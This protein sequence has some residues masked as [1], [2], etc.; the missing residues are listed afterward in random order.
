MVLVPRGFQSW[1]SFSRFAFAREFL[2][3]GAPRERP[4]LEKGVNLLTGILLKPYDYFLRNIYSPP[5]VAAVTL[6][7]LVAVTMFFYPK[8]FHT[9]AC[10]ILP[11]FKR[12]QAKHLRFT[13]FT[14]SQ[15]LIWGIGIRTLSRLNDSALMRAWVQGRAVAVPLGAERV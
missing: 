14:L 12:L 9:A 5:L 8:Q 10:K 4:L 3:D 2:I 11:P 6:T 15:M 1:G 7:A 13:L